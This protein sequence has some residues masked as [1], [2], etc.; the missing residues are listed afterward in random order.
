[1]KTYNLFTSHS[2][3]ADKRFQDLKNLL[4]KRP[5]FKY[6]NY[7]VSVDRPI[8]DAPTPEEIKGRD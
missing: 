8:E 6:K 3:K 2:W 5:Y 4:E 1:M 7:S